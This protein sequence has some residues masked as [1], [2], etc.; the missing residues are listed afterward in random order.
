MARRRRIIPQHEWV[1]AREFTRVVETKVIRSYYKL[2]V[3]GQETI[4]LDWKRDNK[5]ILKLLSEKSDLLILG[6]AIE[7]T[8]VK[9]VRK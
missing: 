6:P 2:R 9:Y 1:N 8:I 3:F 4:T 5:L 7:I